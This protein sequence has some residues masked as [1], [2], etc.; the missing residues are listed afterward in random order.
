MTTPHPRPA[1]ERQAGGGSD[2]AVALTRRQILEAG[3]AGAATAALP[4][5][6]FV[7]APPPPF[8]AALPETTP[9]PEAN[10]ILAGTVRPVFPDAVF[11]VTDFGAVGDGRTD[12]TD[13]F[14]AAITA[15][16]R[17]GGG[18]V[19]VPPGSWL[20]GAL[21]LRSRVDLHLA[22][23]ATLLFSDDPGRFPPVLTRFEGIECINRS[24]M[25]YALGETGVGLTGAGVLDA[26]RTAAWNRGGDRA[27]VL[28]PLVAAGVPPARRVVTGRLRTTFVEPYLCQGV[29]LQGVTLVGAQF[30]QIHPTL[31]TDVTIS[32][33]TTTVSGG[34]SDGCNPESCRR[35]VIARCTLASGDDNIA[36]KSGRDADGR[37]L[38][39]PCRDIVIMNCQAEG[40][41]GFITCGSEQTGGIENVY[42][43]NNWTYGRGVGSVLWIK[44]N[45]HRGGFTRNVAVDTFTGSNLRH[46]VLDVTMTYDDLPGAFPPS[47][48]D[49]RLSRLAV[50]GARHVLDLE[51]LDGAPVGP[52]TVSDSRFT[53]ITGAPCR[54]RHATGVTCRDVT[55]DGRPLGCG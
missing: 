37:R 35:V 45:R 48:G 3:L 43:Y 40:R 21:R 41:F 6:L 49:L 34:N 25:I 28:E 55:V 7:G 1:V 18:H 2:A 27:G 23:G 16:H 4:G 14:L 26:S 30:W 13:A 31:C 12:D 38:A 52:V 46:A 19:T 11:P 36:L 29:L 22:A 47:F 17:A 8:P 39:T 50:S 42:A 54:L 24:P 5:C 10:A 33:V 15:C 44:S 20:V 32:G 53:G 51:G 9:W